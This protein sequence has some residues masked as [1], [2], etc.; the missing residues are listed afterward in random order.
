MQA[1]TLSVRLVKR[2]HCTT[3]LIDIMH[4]G[5]RSSMAYNAYTSDSRI[6]TCRAAGILAHPNSS[7]VF[8]HEQ[9]VMYHVAQNSTASDSGAQPR[10]LPYLSKSGRDY[11]VP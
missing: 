7:F 8:R 11:V 4:Q 2:R 3:L 10:R 1:I 5:I 6:T 9:N